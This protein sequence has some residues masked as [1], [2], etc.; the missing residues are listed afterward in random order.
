MTAVTLSWPTTG[1]WSGV[2]AARVV[3]Y[4]IYV[5]MVYLFEFVRMGPQGP[6]TQSLQRNWV[7]NL[8]FIFFLA[9]KHH[10]RS[11]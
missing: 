7:A 2:L 4:F 5:Y 10:V 8:L 11:W 3:V 9:Y 1:M 6:Y